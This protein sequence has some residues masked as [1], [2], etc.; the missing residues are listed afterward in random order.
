MSEKT[1]TQHVGELVKRA[2]IGMLTTMTSE[3][4]HVSRPMALQR[5]E[6]DGDLWFFAYQDSDKVAQ[7]S[8]HPE[9]NV[10]FA[11]SKQSEWT[12]VSG[13]AEVVHDRAKAEEL[14][15]APLKAWFEDG[16]DTPGLTLIKVHADSAEYWESPS[17]KVVRL[18]G[19]AAAAATGDSDKFPGKNETVNL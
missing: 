14:W 2:E 8:V 5:T 18:V 9:V 13:T 6:F 10:G 17:S 12:S 19:M 16:L 1:P 4:R 11:N 3:G 15:S 7:I